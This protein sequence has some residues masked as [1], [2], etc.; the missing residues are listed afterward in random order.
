[1][2]NLWLL[3]AAVCITL[4][5]SCGSNHRKPATWRTSDDVHI[6]VDETFRDIMEEEIETFGLLNP[7]SAMKPVYCSEDSAIRMLLRDS[8]RC[9]ITTRKLSK[10]ELD[11]LKNYKLDAKQAMIATDAFAL[12]VSKDN[13]DTLIT[14]S[15]IGDIVT[16]RMTRSEQLKNSGK[17]G[18]LKLVFDNSGSSTVRYMRDSLLAGQQVAGNL[19]AQ[20]S[21]QA[22]IDAVKDNPEI[23]GVVGANW[24]KGKSDSVLTSFENLDVKVLK[25][26]RKDGKNEIGWR[27]YQ[28]RILTGDYPL[29]RSV[30]VILTDPRV[31][32]YTKSF[33]YFLKGQKGQ[34]IIC[35]SSQLLPY[36][37][38]QYKSI[39]AN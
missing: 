20:G 18:E 28:Y 12:I 4:A 34:T 26:A 24:L 6:A 30:Y 15:E 25:V 27:P 11:V 38:V 8:V 17:K 1:M 35:N 31:R 5:T 29:I 33:F 39:R 9:A 23:I 19:Y 37:P 14:V 21:N 2:R 32:S 13:P 10:D 36:T 3:V 7:A 22:V 16:G